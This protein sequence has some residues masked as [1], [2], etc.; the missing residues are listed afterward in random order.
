MAPVTRQTQASLRGAHTLG[1]DNEK[2]SS[3]QVS[4]FISNDANVA[5]TA[6]LN[7]NLQ[8]IIKVIH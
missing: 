5:N 8:S 2:Q 3:L 6:P 1:L 7:V 4:T